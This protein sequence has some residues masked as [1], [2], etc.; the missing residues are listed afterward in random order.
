[1]RTSNGK[2]VRLMLCFTPTAFYVPHPEFEKVW[3]DV[4][5]RFDV[6]FL[7]LYKE[8]TALRISFSPMSET[9]GEDH[10]DSNGHFFMGMLLAHD[11]LRD[12][13]IPWRMDGSSIKKSR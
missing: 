13:L 4:A 3:E 9:R 12:G 10:F 8:M 5:H 6:P 7:D 11:L 1:M 2:P